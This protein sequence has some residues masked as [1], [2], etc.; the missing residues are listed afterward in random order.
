MKKLIVTSIVTLGTVGTLSG[1]FAASNSST[2]TTKSKSVLDDM[3]LSYINELSLSKNSGTSKYQDVGMV[4]IASLRYSLNDKY[5]L[6]AYHRFDSSFNHGKAATHDSQYSRII[7]SKSGVLTQ[8]RNGVDSSVY[9]RLQV[10]SEA[11]G[12]YGYFKTAITYG[13]DLTNTLSIGG[14]FAIG[15]DI[16]TK[17]ADRQLDAKGKHTAT[18]RAY[19]YLPLTLNKKINDKMDID[20]FT[21]EYYKG[22]NSSIDEAGGHTVDLSSS[23]NYAALDKLSL[24]TGI[25]FGT[26]LNL[27]SGGDIVVFDKEN[28]EFS[29]S[30]SLSV[31]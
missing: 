16:L 23:L 31:F 11:T 25:A 19:V 17:D 28:I 6:S 21:A 1:A 12:S 22:I 3:S 7:L 2:I 20:L 10:K 24:S 29:V 18:R 15:K 27:G 14:E 30:A 8:K 9:T 26:V 5:A 4:Q 13:K